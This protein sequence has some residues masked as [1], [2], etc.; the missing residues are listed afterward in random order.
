MENHRFPPRNI[1]EYIVSPFHPRFN[2]SWRRSDS[3][4]SESGAGGEGEDQLW[5]AGLRP[6]GHI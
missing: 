3:T 4:V 2:R 6:E 5:N 1:D